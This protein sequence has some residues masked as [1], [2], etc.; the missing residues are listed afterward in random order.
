VGF[1]L[2]WFHTQVP[3]SK[4]VSG[5][6]LKLP[7]LKTRKLFSYT[8]VSFQQ[9]KRHHTSHKAKHTQTPSEVK[10]LSK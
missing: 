2:N 1:D 7:P 3:R 9:T 10:Y 4:E 8:S 6:I 5:S